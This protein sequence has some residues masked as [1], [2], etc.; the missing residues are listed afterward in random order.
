MGN[1]KPQIEGH[2]VKKWLKEKEQTMTYKTPHRNAKIE[3][4]DK[5]PTKR[6]GLVQSGHQNHM[7]GI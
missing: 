6:V 5:N 2:T 7:I 1:Q 3:Q 4:H